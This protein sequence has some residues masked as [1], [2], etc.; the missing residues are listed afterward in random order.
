MTQLSAG[1]LQK[2]DREIRIERQMYP[3]HRTLQTGA[4]MLPLQFAHGFVSYL[5]HYPYACTEQIVSQAMPAVLLK[6]RPEFGTVISQ[7]GGDIAGLV[8]ELRARQ[9]DAGAYKLWPG[10]EVVVEF[11][12]LYAQ[13]FLL[14]AAEREEAVPGDLIANGNVFL[15]AIA[16]RDGNNLTDERQ[17]AYAIY[18]LTRQ[19]ERMSTE[20]AA[21]RK[22][23]E[24]RYRGQW[25]Q[26]LT[27]AWL[28]AALDLM[29]QDREAGEL[30]GRTRFGLGA[31]GD[32]YNDPM[33]RDALLLFVMARHFP[34]RLREMPKD[35]LGTLAKRVDESY[36]HS[37]SAGT[38]LLALD[39]YS[40]ATQGAARN[41]SLAEVL[42]D[43]RVQALVLK[44]VTFPKT[45]F[46]EQAAALRFTNNSDLS[47]YY[48]IEQSGFDRRPPT[49]AI[50][51]GFEVLREYTDANGKPLAKIDMGQQVDVHLKFR[52][53]DRDS[54][55]SVALVDLLPGGFE[56]VVPS[57]DAGAQTG[58]WF[59]QVCVEPTKADVQYADMREDRVVFYVV[60][61]KGMS[62]IVY[63]IKATNVGTYV[64]PPAYGEAMYDRSVMGRSPAGKLEVSRP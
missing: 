17:T 12:S 61:A 53:I 56:L 27:A 34:E 7:D 30:I 59:C 37:L 4:S 39:A 13:H 42:K 1:V 58:E 32:T 31:T 16:A 11:V 23:L 21:A 24:Q 46:S 38:T 49:E 40:N 8:T 55:D 3:H 5:A 54:V 20:I 41:L 6:S 63:R 25:E 9:S 48:T 15:R 51:K 10:S 47:A 22:R 64:V 19:G 36:Y 35:M 28:A 44:Q 60:A 57:Q 62:E 52:S 50:R 33:T 45:A 29:H 43:K 2:G 26:D 14:E 18:L